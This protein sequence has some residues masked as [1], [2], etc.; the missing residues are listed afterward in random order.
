MKF[1][2]D[3]K[4][5][6]LILK[7]CIEFIGGVLLFKLICIYV[8][9]LENYYL[10]YLLFIILIILYRFLENIKQDSFSEFDNKRKENLFNTYYI[11][12]K[13]VFEIAMLIDNK[14][15]IQ[16]EDFYK[17]EIQNT[18]SSSYE[19]GIEDGSFNFGKKIGKESM[20]KL[21][22]EYKEVQ[23]IKNTNSIYL[24]TIL[25]K[26]KIIK[27]FNSLEEG[28][29]V[30]INNVKI[31]INNEDELF[32]AKSLINGALNGNTVNTV[33]DGQTYKIDVTSLSNMMIKD[34]KY[35]LKCAI[36]G[37]EYDKNNKNF[38]I[39]IPMKIENEFENDYSV[40][41]LEI[42]MVN[43]IGVYRGHRYNNNKRTTYAKLQDYNS[44]EDNLKS[45][46]KKKQKREKNFKSQSHYVD[47]IAIIQ[48]LSFV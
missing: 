30:R 23:E 32:Q 24:R 7:L 33:S 14:I 26:C 20:R 8:W 19:L 18:Q 28:E 10:L 6:R 42:G 40:Y 27:D 38:Y 47:V 31:K 17:K 21:G 5:I 36:K 11:N 12:Y 44:Q 1:I 43:I 3:I 35:N 15:R 4:Q 37:N 25:N 22:H 34:Y 46:N 48:D 9:D 41:D 39:E 2:I 13:K 16:A 29:L 45:S